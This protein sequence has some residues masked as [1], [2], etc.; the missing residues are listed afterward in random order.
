MGT[1]ALVREVTTSRKTSR[2]VPLAG[3]FYGLL[4]V[5]GWFWLRQRGRSGLTAEI[6]I[7]ADG[8]LVALS[9]GA[10]TG[11]ALAGITSGLSRYLAPF[12]RL[13]HGLRELVGPLEERDR[14]STRLNSSHG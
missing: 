5:V 1:K 11:L 12:R 14:K 6:A 4:V 3:A 10:G 7:G 9:L 13:D 2:I 8:L